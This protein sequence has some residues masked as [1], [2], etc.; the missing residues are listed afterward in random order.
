MKW[1]PGMRRCPASSPY[2]GIGRPANLSGRWQKIF[3]KMR[4]ISVNQKQMTALSPTQEVG[5]EIHPSG[6][7]FSF[8][9]RALAELTEDESIPNAV[10]LRQTILNETLRQNR[11][12]ETPCSAGKLYTLWNHPLQ[13]MLRA[14]GAAAV[15]GHVVEPLKTVRLIYV[16]CEQDLRI[17]ET[18]LMQR[19]YKLD[20]EDL[21]LLNAE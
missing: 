4:R 8:L 19:G 10:R 16:A 1:V 9:L 20:V 15:I 17:T 5:E 12:Q 6:N 21:F 2:N 11:G 13:T 3:L 7:G 18:L 14:N